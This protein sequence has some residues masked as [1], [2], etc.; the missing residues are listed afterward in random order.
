MRLGAGKRFVEPNW[1]RRLAYFLLG[2]PH[3]PGWIRLQHVL[4]QIR[5]LNVNGSAA[6]VLDAG[7][8]R[9]DLSVYLAE[10]HPS[11]SFVGV[12]LMPDR[13]EIAE[14]IRQKACLANVRYQV[15]DL[16]D[17]PFKRSEEHTSELQSHSFI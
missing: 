7:C 10:R 17:L 4:R 15:A 12:E 6:K 5:A 9:G 3:V 1:K 16:C 11:W 8:S 2:E 14:R 13:V